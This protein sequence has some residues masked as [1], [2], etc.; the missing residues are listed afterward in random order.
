MIKM[1]VE[2]MSNKI[3]LILIGLWTGLIV[4]AG[5]EM[6]MVVIP[7]GF[8][9]V[10]VSIAELV[11]KKKKIIGVVTMI[12]IIAFFIT[13]AVAMKDSQAAFMIMGMFTTL[14]ALSIFINPDRDT[15]ET[16]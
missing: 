1:E 15:F 5:K 10:F 7:C 4:V 12:L 16:F 6:S 8:F 14:T 3:L 13:G 2:K 11:K 9:I